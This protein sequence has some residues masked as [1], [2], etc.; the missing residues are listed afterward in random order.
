MPIDTRELME[1]VGML[2]D[3]RNVRVTIKS[4]AKGAMVC[5]TTCFI[6]G[7]LGGPVGLAVGGTIGAIGAGM[8]SKGKFRSVN[9]IIMQEMSDR[10]REQLKERILKALSQF[11]PTDMAVLLPLIMGNAAAQ[12]AI[13]STVI[14]FVTNEMKMQIVD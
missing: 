9:E 12:Q 5:G 13:L 2:T 10:E 7:L 1:A 14:S 8:M 11:H 4:S 3:Q 6:G